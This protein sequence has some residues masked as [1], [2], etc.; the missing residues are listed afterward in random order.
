MNAT[1]G[2]T[3]FG[4]HGA[5]LGQTTFCETTIGAA[6]S[7]SQKV[8]ADTSVLGQSISYTLSRQNVPRQ[9]VDY[10]QEDYYVSCSKQFQYLKNNILLSNIDCKRSG[11]V[12]GEDWL[13][14]NMKIA[15]NFKS[16]NY[17]PLLVARIFCNI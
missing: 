15:G 7:G 10:S 16:T 2:L 4:H 17:S 14:A 9:T 1:I 12:T 6:G 8:S 11:V 3:T 13:H 5:T